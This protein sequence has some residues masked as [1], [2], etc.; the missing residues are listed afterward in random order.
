S[1]A[2]A[3]RYAV[4][5]LGRPALNA[6]IVVA[7]AGNPGRAVARAAADLDVRCTVF[8]PAMAADIGDDERR[9]RVNRVAGMRADGAQVIEVA[10]TYE[11]AV[12]LA[13]TYART[14]GAT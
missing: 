11:E 8:V 4:E 13:A 7:T 1:K 9:V 2:S 6:G 10:G 12:E 14:E 3:A 5:Q